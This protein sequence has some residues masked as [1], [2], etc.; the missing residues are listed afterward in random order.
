MSPATYIRYTADEILHYRRKSHEA[1]RF[2]LCCEKDTAVAHKAESVPNCHSLLPL[3]VTGCLLVARNRARNSSDVPETLNQWMLMLELE[4][5]MYVTLEIK[6]VDTAGGVLF[7]CRPETTAPVISVPKEGGVLRL[8][9]YAFAVKSHVSFRKT[10]NH[11]LCVLTHNQC[12]NYHLTDGRGK[13]TDL[14]L[15]LSGKITNIYS[16]L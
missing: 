9:G 1:S 13:S 3:Q 15:I 4:K 6:S 5:Y 10:L 7:I 2:A 16:S 12:L 8:G 11:W 14:V